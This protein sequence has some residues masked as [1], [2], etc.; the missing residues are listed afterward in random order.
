M[1]FVRPG[2]PPTLFHF[3]RSRRAARPR[4]EN[5]TA[6]VLLPMENLK[7]GP[8]YCGTFQVG[9]TVCLRQDDH[10]TLR[11]TFSLALSNS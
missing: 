3:A 2:M 6:R 5:V 9:Y 10:A 7:N 1:R 8:A 11:A 4:V